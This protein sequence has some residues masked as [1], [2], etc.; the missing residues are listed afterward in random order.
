MIDIYLVSIYIAGVIMFF[1][2]CVFPILPVYLAVLERGGKKIRNTIFFLSGLSFT[3]VSLGFGVGALADYIY[4][5]TVRVITGILVVI[6]GLQQ[7][8]IFNLKILNQTRIVNVKKYENPAVESLILGLSFGLGWTPCVG[9]I[10]ATVLAYAGDTSSNIYGA[11][12]LLV[13]VLGF[14]T[15][16]II[17]TFFYDRLS[18]KLSI[19]KNNLEF[20]KKLGAV[21]IIFLGLGLIFD[22]FA[23]LSA[24]FNSISL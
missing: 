15:P 22:K 21:L 3:F 6:F 1:S 5:P 13:F 8:G 23:Y 12:L 7:Y 14:T 19:I 20:I 11:F 10:L 4:T 24:F 17:F 18:N 9:P 16:F 2:P